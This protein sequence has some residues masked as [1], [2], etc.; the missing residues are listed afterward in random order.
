ME[1]DLPVS[2]AAVSNVQI[3]PDIIPS[4]KLVDALQPAS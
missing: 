4:E 1:D 2:F 3:L